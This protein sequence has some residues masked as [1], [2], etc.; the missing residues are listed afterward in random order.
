MAPFYSVQA[1]CHHGLQAKIGIELHILESLIEKNV[2]VYVQEAYGGHADLHFFEF[3]CRSHLA[4]GMFYDKR[5]A[6]V[7]I[8]AIKKRESRWC[9]YMG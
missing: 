1:G 4:C 6:D 5:D 9:R 2:R 3:E 8:T 7:A